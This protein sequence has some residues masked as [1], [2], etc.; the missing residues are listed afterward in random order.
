MNKNQYLTIDEIKL[1]KKKLQQ[2]ID[3]IEE[4]YSQKATKIEGRIR[5]TLQPIQTIQKNPFKSIGAAI[6]V[7]FIIGYSGRKKSK[8]SQSQ[9]TQSTH[10]F[11]TEP[12]G[13]TPL[14][15]NELKRMAVHRAMIY[16][17]GLVDHKIIPGITAAHK[18]RKKAESNRDVHTS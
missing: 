18:N 2:E 17:T 6:A 7:G 8:T 14:L 5:S 10:T 1:R 4:K 16:L 11:D 9:P 13:F 15:M 3:H 12:S